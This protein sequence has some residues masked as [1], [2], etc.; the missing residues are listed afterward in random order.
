MKIHTYVESHISQLSDGEAHMV[1]WTS[2]PKTT[3]NIFCYLFY[4]FSAENLYLFLGRKFS[5]I[6]Y[7]YA[8]RKFY[9]PKSKISIGAFCSFLVEF[10]ILWG[11]WRE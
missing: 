5:Y 10:I 11:K 7:V 1:F 6:V 4:M 8:I 9:G 2:R 3:R